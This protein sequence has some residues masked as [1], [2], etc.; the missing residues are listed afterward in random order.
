MDEGSFVPECPGVVEQLRNLLLG[1][2]MM[3]IE[4]NNVKEWEKRLGWGIDMK[5]LGQFLAREFP[6]V[7]AAIVYQ[8]T[9]EESEGSVRFIKSL[10]QWGFVVRTKRVKI[11]TVP[12][13][14]RRPFAPLLPFLRERFLDEVSKEN[15][16]VIEELITTLHAINEKR[17]QRGLPPLRRLKGNFDTEIAWDMR[18]D[19]DQDQV[20][21]VGL[22]SCDGDFALPLQELRMAK[23]AVV[24]FA[25]GEAAGELRTLEER[26]G[27]VIFDVARL[28]PYISNEKMKGTPEGRP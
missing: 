2:V 26:Y 27:I 15:L 22:W 23:K 6:N 17:K 1:R 3:Y 9:V 18:R 4:Y 13:S 10:S 16:R 8:G 21:C 20:D 7:N 28:Q 14:D 12:V 11:Q 25:A 24:V 19:L 5:R